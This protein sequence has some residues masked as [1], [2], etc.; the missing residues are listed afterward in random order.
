MVGDY[1]GDGMV[2]R[3]RLFWSVATRRQLDRWEPFVAAAVRRDLTRQTLGGAE[4]WAA[5]MEHHFALVA[6]RNLIR[7]LDLPPASGVAIDPTVRAELIE[8][9]DL[10]E[11]GSRTC[12]CST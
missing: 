10:S 3:Q 7:A 2:N 1:F 5:E 4:I 8:G 12:R 9:R 11:H 6:A